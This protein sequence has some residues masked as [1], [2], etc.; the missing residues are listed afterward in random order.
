MQPQHQEPNR[1]DWM[2][3]TNQVQFK[4]ADLLYH[5]AE[6]SVPITDTLLMLWANS[7]AGLNDSAPF[8]NHNELHLTINKS[9]LEDVPWECLMTSIPDNVNKSDPSWMQKSYEVWYCNPEA[10]VS[11]MLSNPDFEGQ[12]DLW[13]YINL[14]PDG[15]HQ[16]NNIMLGTLA[17][18]NSVSTFSIDTFCDVYWLHAFKDKIFALDPSMEGAMYYP[19]IL[20]SDKTTVLV[21][22]GQ[23][24]YHPVYLLIGNP[25]NAVQHAHQNAVIPIAFLPIPKCKWLYSNVHAHHSLAIRW[26][27]VW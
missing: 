25:H 4:L 20:G 10:F 6:L 24:K 18:R 13:P 9:S 26:S 15:T 7:M 2:P 22:M 16:W 8:K 12:F 3:F 23:V 11:A 5:N 21:T 19:I 14:N 27:Q 17:W 1:E